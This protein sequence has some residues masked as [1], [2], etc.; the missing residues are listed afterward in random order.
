MQGLEEEQQGLG[1]AGLSRS[2]QHV[3]EE[4][5]GWRN[6]AQVCATEGQASEGVE[7]ACPAKEERE[8]LSVAVMPV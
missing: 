1:R 6:C 4:E 5:L 3:G 2:L 7:A 8:A